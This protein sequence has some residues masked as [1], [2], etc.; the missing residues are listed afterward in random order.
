ML[1][2]S[3]ALLVAALGVFAMGGCASD[4]GSAT[5][6]LGSGPPL[7]PI[8]PEAT[9]GAVDG[10]ETQLS[11]AEQFRVDPNALVV[12]LDAD[13]NPLCIDTMLAI[14]EELRTL[15][16][17]ETAERVLAAYNST[18]G[19]LETFG[20]YSTRDGAPV[21]PISAT[22]EP[23]PQPSRPMDQL[24][25]PAKGDPN[26]QPSS[27]RSGGERTEPNPQPSTPL[28]PPGVCEVMNEASGRL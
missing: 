22:T 6:A 7:A 18:I 15:G 2:V 13:G 8:A 20:E 3:V 14:A 11:D 9:F 27:P 1:V 17:V 4:V 24:Q 21:T 26:P 12:A 10:C 5:V 25:D 19:T 28:L 23:N 16:A